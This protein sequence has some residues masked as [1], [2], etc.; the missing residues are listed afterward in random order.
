[1]T[2]LA[3]GAVLGAALLAVFALGTQLGRPN[4]AFVLFVWLYVV[5]TVLVLMFVI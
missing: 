2:G 1:L 4:A 3:A 5:M